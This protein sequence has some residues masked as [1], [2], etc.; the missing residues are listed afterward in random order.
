MLGCSQ[1]RKW[2][3]ARTRVKISEKAVNVQRKTDQ[4]SEMLQ[5]YRSRLLKILQESTA[6]WNEN[7]KKKRGWLKTQYHI[8]F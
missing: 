3:A 5:D 8:L 6:P 2:T 7:I 1:V 4:L